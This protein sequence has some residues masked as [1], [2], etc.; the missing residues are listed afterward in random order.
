MPKII[1]MIPGTPKYRKGFLI[2]IC[3][4]K[5]AATSVPCIRG[6]FV[7]V[8]EPTL[9]STVTFSSEILNPFFDASSRISA[10]APNPSVEKVIFLIVKYLLKI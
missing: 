9:Y 2:K 8:F 5:D 6:F 7:E 10:S 4:I 3:S 1:D